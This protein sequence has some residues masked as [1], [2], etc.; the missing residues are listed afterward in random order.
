MAD[1]QDDYRLGYRPDVEGLRAVA[2]LL[3]VAA[4]AGVGILQGGFVGVDVFYILSGYLIT[5]LL[6]QESATTG[7]LGFAR[8]Y[9]RRLRRLLP[10]LLLMLAVTCV[11]AHFLVPPTELPLQA[12]TASSA[13]VWLSNFQ[14]ALWNWDY[15]AP[16]SSASLYLHTWSLGVEEQFYLVW[17]LLIVLALGAWRLSAGVRSTAN[18]KWL[19]AGIF[20]LSFALSLFWTYR[21]SMFAFYLMPARAWQFALGAL[22]FLAVGSPAFDVRS[23]IRT[24]AWLRPAGWIGVAMILLGAWIIDPAAPYPGTWALLPS[25]GA[26]LVLAAGAYAGTAGIR[27]LLSWRPLQAIGRVSYSW[28]L[29][30]WPVLLLGAI[31]L[32]MTNGWNR[33]LLV[34]LS[35][36]IAALSYHF[37][38]TPIRHMRRLVAKP[39]LAIAGALVAMLVTVGVLQIWKVTAQS[40]AAE[41]QFASFVAA[42]HDKAAIYTK[43]C[44]GSYLSTDVQ[45]CNLGD[46]NAK[47]TAVV[48]GDSKAAQWL[49]A[50]RE[51]FTARDWQLLAIAKSACPMVDA[52]YIAPPLRRAYTECDE[53]RAATLRQV[54]AMRPDVVVLGESLEYPFTPEQWERGTRRVLQVLAPHVARIYVMRPTPELPFDPR[55]CPEPRGW[56]YTTLAGKDRCTSPAYTPRFNEVGERLRE[57]S[58]PFHNVQFVDMTNRVCPGGLCQPILGGRVM[59]RDSVHLTATFAR[60]LAP[61]L[62]VA[63]R[64]D[65]VGE[66][67]VAGRPVRQKQG[68]P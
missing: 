51:V 62:A 66:P 61:S 55:V 40:R 8:F 48:L 16:S 68:Q 1:K 53:W 57:A 7:R 10:A 18:L 30:H 34:V 25:F 38:E 15:F 67:V 49:P 37:F 39:R 31:V 24:S 11:A 47:R 41:P 19:F 26:A 36:G 45:V 14:F 35:L 20:V 32:D 21:S 6:V 17:P 28:Y 43:G 63:L 44:F 58:E 46:S 5:G 12:S 9:A 56:L 54:A 23:R 64:L 3:V 65:E 29:W 60:T 13:A 59:F 52:T 2:I 22:V 42:A 27:T 33:L 50:L 4:H